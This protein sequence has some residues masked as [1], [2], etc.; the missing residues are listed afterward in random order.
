LSPGG[1]GVPLRRAARTARGPGVPSRPARPAL[2]R[3]LLALLAV[4]ARLRARLAPPRLGP[5]PRPSPTPAIAC[6][7]GARVPRAASA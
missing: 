5:I 6:L 7:R 2:R 1:R 4:S 3:S